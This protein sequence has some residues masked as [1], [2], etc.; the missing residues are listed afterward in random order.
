MIMEGRRA[1][2]VLLTIVVVFAIAP[3]IAILIYTF[4]KEGQLDFSQFSRMFAHE[5]LWQTLGNSI[6]LGIFVMLGT[7]LIAFPMAFI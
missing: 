5:R 6:G 4:T 7:T 3:L 1:F 2:G